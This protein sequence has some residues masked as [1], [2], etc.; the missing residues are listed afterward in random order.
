MPSVRLV[1][2][3][4]CSAVVSA[5]VDDTGVFSPPSKVD[6]AASAPSIDASEPGLDGGT[7]APSMDGGALIAYPTSNIGGRPR[8]ST[9]PGQTLANLTLQGI[10]GV[11]G[12]D[13]TVTVS[14]SDYFDPQGARYDLLHVMALFMWCPHCNNEANNLAKI[15]GWQSSHRVASVQIAM[16]GYGGDTPTWDELKKWVSD[17]N[18]PVPV[19]LDAQG[20]QLGQYFKVTSVPINIV[21]NPRTMEILAVDIGEVGDVQGYE[22]R[23]LD[24][25]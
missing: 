20:A 15:A 12:L 9:E 13:Q 21:V 14:M 5:C 17:H 18:L 23:F 8:S 19:L 4:A 10:P 3:L 2:L 25:L 24:A 6:A 11:A 1:I 7:G 16:Q 22:Q